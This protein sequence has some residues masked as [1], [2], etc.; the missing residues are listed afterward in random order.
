M[1]VIIKRREK[2]KTTKTR[3]QSRKKK[4]CGATGILRGKGTDS[5]LFLLHWTR[6][7]FWFVLGNWGKNIEDACMFRHQEYRASRK[8]EALTRN[9]ER[10]K[11]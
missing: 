4:A 8:K 2:K 7:I 6:L 1:T 3:E 9:F 11:K 5:G 10:E